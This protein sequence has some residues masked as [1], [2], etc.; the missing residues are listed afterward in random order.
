MDRALKIIEH[1]LEGI[2]ANKE[3][4]EK[5]RFSLKKRGALLYWIGQATALE[6]IKKLLLIYQ[7][8]KEAE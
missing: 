2:Y 4:V 6:R 1:E 3:L 7:L 5:S 8:A